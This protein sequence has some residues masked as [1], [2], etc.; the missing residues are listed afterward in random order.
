MIWGLDLNRPGSA[1]V[2]S[3]WALERGLIVEAARLKDEVLLI[4][5]ALTIDETTLLD[6][7]YRLDEAVSEYLSLDQRHH[8]GQTTS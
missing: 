2:I 7:L 6:G 3:A 8:V 1:A 5:P 4:R